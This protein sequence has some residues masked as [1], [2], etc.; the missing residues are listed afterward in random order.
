MSLESI[1]R[2]L[3]KGGGNIR[4]PGWYFVSVFGTPAKTGKW[5]WRI[6]G[7]HLSLNYLVEDGKVVAATPA[8]FGANPATVREGPR[9][10]LRAIPDVDDLA[11]EL[12][13]VAR[14]RT[15]ATGRAAGGQVPEE[16]VSRSR[17][18]RRRQGRRAGGRTGGEN[19]RA[20]QR[21]T[22]EKLLH[23]YIDRLPGDVAQAELDRIQQA[24]IDK[25]YFAFA[26]GTEARSA[27]HLPAAR[28]DLRR[29]IPQRPGG[30][31]QEPGQPHS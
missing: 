15:A 21:A 20:K 14:R 18:P 26:G 16:T 11:R 7:H 1:L 25:V 19:V 8:F 6:E 9:K 4:N 31:R 24:G 28:A 2:E 3:E 22:L 13:R 27:A 17:C 30:Q 12:Y 23:A 10:G 5:G 29:R